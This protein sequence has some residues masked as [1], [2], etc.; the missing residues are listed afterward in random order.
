M[1]LLLSLIHQWYFFGGEELGLDRIMVKVATLNAR[2][3]NFRHKVYPNSLLIELPSWDLFYVV[4]LV[5]GK[6]R[7]LVPGKR[8]QT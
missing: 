7:G 5:G 2:I 3:G 4:S 1:H 6:A 8:L